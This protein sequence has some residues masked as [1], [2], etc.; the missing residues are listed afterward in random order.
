[1]TDRLRVGIAGVGAIHEVPPVQSSRQVAGH[2]PIENAATVLF[3]TA[4]GA[5][6]TVVISQGWAG[7]KNWP[8]GG[9]PE[10]CDR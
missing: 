4:R 2:G 3:G 10:I 7:R 8:A 5:L 9:L 6:G 1:M